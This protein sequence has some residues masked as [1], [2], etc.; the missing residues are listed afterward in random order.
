MYTSL[1][2]ANLYVGNPTVTFNLPDVMVDSTHALAFSAA[3][4]SSDA[5]VYLQGTINDNVPVPASVLLLGS[6]LLGLAGWRWR[7]WLK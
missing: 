2:S 1:F 5:Q 3:Q 4:G 7:P 6:G